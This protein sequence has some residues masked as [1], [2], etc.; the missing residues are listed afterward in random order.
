METHHQETPLVEL[1]VKA[2]IQHLIVYQHQVVAKVVNLEVQVVDQDTKD[3]VEQEMLVVLVHRKV[4]MVVRPEVAV[5]LD[6][7]AE[8]EVLVVPRVLLV[9]QDRALAE[10]D[11]VVQ[12]VLQPL[13]LVQVNL[14]MAL[15]V[16][17]L[18]AVV[19]APHI[20][21]TQ[22]D[23]E[24]LE[25]VEIMIVTLMLIKVAAVAHLV[26]KQAHLHLE[27]MV[28]MVEYL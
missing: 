27:E 8:A 3:Q 18:L 7:E 22:V 24:A 6:L 14:S 1:V 4:L 19:L 11:Q 28:Q 23:L 16:Q 9:V 2:V 13:L 21:Q 10:E 5:L 15:M 20:T 12:E 17:F 26:Q 25:A